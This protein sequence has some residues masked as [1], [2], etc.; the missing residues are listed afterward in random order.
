MLRQPER[1]WPA[2]SDESHLCRVLAALPEGR[3]VPTPQT[4]YSWAAVAA[5]LGCVVTLLS[6]APWPE[7]RESLSPLVGVFSALSPDLEDPSLLAGLVG[8]TVPLLTR[9]PVQA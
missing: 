4:H 7:L 6:S 5:T 9:R 2:E 1:S 8:G 3:S